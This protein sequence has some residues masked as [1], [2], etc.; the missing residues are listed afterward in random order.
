MPQ[1]VAAY[2]WRPIGNLLIQNSTITGN[3]AKTDGG[4]MAI[5]GFDAFAVLDLT[6]LSNITLRSTIIA[7]NSHD[8]VQQ[9]AL[10]D[11]ASYKATN[12]TANNNLIGIQDATTNIT[13]VGANNKVGD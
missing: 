12:V 2:S 11:I 4:G 13:L 9:T 7:N 5:K 1:A 6:A 3:N 10:A 8:N